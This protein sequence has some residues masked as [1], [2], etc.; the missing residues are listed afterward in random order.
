M[1]IT[2]QQIEEAMESVPATTAQ[3]I[4]EED[5][6]FFRIRR[7]WLKQAVDNIMALLESA[8]EPSQSPKKKL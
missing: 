5:G 7:A 8:S 4:V 6:I 1:K 3:D 2:R